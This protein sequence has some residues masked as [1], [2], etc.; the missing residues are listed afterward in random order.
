M[1]S[2]MQKI[3]FALLLLFSVFAPSS[4]A[5]QFIEINHQFSFISPDGHTIV[6]IAPELGFLVLVT[7]EKYSAQDFDPAQVPIDN[8]R[9]VFVKRDH[10][11]YSEVLLRNKSVPIRGSFGMSIG[12]TT[13]LAL[14]DNKINQFASIAV[15]KGKDSAILVISGDQVLFN[16]N[17]EY[18]TYLAADGLLKAEYKGSISDYVLG[19]DNLIYL[20]GALFK[21]PGLGVTVQADSA[22]ARQGVMILSEKDIAEMRQTHEKPA[23]LAKRT[24]SLTEVLPFVVTSNSMVVMDM[25][26]MDLRM[27]TRVTDL[28][29]LVGSPICSYARVNIK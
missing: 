23:D 12:S 26:T 16:K 9:Q 27:L 13:T 5:A 8:A 17:G 4:S 2:T 3:L 29:D 21:G 28:E 10:G 24:V 7:E 11:S 22:C 25:Q 1:S 20:K 15:E 18:I 14:N 19:L 6:L